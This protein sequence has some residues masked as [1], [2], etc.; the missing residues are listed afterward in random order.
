MD[1]SL[2]FVFPGP[3]SQSLGMLSELAAAHPIVRDS[4]D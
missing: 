4:F 2:A 3:G 1:N